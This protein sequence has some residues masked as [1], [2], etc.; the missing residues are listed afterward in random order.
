MLIPSASCAHGTRSLRSSEVRHAPR[1]PPP[2]P[3]R[4]PS[5]WV[6]GPQDSVAD[7][8]VAC[9]GPSSE[10]A[11]IRTSPRFAARSDRGRRST[12]A[13][14]ARQK[15]TS[16]G[17]RSPPPARGLAYGSTQALRRRP[18]HRRRFQF[19]ERNSGKPNARHRAA[20]WRSTSGLARRLP[21]TSPASINPCPRC[22]CSSSG[23]GIRQIEAGVP[24]DRLEII[25]RQVDFEPL[26]SPGSSA[27]HWRRT[28]SARSR[29]RWWCRSC[30]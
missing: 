25:Q 19:D 14:T 7:Y 24:Q 2:A 15:K 21:R 10:V 23:Y 18:R 28:P 17:K 8:V 11:V 6:S 5:S 3:A 12:A 27:P 22:W 4:S 26:M 13:P 29:P 1:P 9:R 30:G 16:T 20:C